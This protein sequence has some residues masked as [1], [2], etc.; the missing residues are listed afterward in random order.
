MMNKIK[1]EI[2]AVATGIALLTL[3]LAT[4]CQ[5]IPA[6]PKNPTF[7]EGENPC[8]EGQR[9]VLVENMSDEFNGKKVDLEKWQVEPNENGWNWDGR[10]PALFQAERVSVGDGS[11]NIEVGV[12]EEPITK[13]D[14]T[15]EYYGAIVRSLNP[16]QMG[17]Y[18]ECRMKANATEMSSTFWLNTKGGGETQELDIQ[19]CVGKTSELTDE[20]GRNWDRI[21]HSNTIFW[22]R[23]TDPLRQQIQDGYEMEVKNHSDYFVY[24]AWWKSAEEVRFYLNGK[25]MY[26]LHPE[27]VW[28]IPAYLHMAIEKYDWNPIPAD[29]GLLASGTLEERTTTYDWIRTWKLVH[30]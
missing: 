3:V 4:S 19:E 25:Y 27:V 16:G 15:F 24:A 26:S 22:R 14:K 5:T 13:K 30:P 7:A 23:G 10:V 29:G 20:W 6:G 18:Y 1:I 8:P 17:W 11:M 21:F 28:D 2:V 12:L 9:W